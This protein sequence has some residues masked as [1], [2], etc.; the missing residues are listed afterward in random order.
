MVDTPSSSEVQPGSQSSTLIDSASPFYIHPSDSLGMLLAEPL[1]SDP[2]HKLWD[3]CNDMVISWILNYLSKDIAESV[4]YSRTAKEIW[5]DL[6]ARFGQC[7]GAQLY[8]LQKELSNAVQGNTNIAGYF[9]RIKK[10]WDEL[11]A[12]ITLNHCSCVCICGGKIKTI[13]S[14]Q[15]GRLIQFLMGLNSSYSS[16]KSSILM[17]DPLPSVSQAYSLLIQDE[18]Q[19]EVHMESSPSHGAFSVSHQQFGHNQRFNNTQNFLGN[20]DGRFKTQFDK[21][22]TGLFCTHCKLT[23]H[24]V[25]KCYR[26]IGFPPN[27]KFTKSKKEKFAAHSTSNV[28]GDQSPDV[29]ASANCAGIFTPHFNPSFYYFSSHLTSNS[30]ILDLGASDHMNFDYSLLSNVTHLPTLLYVNLPNSHKLKVTHKGSV[31]I[32]PNLVIDNVLFVPDFKFNLLSVQKL[33]SQFHCLLTFFSSGAVF[34]V[35]SMKSPLV[36]SEVH[37]GL[38]IFKSAP[39]QSSLVPDSSCPVSAS[40]FLSKSVSSLQPCWQDAMAKEFEALQLNHTWDLV[41]LPLGKRALPSKWVYKVKYKA[42]GSIERYKARLVIQGDVQRAAVAI[43]KGWDLFQLDVN[44]AFLHGNLQEEVYMRIP[45]GLQVSGSN[46]IKDLGLAHYFLGLELIREEQGLIVTQRKFTTDLLSEF[47]CLDKKPVV[48]PLEPSTKLRVDVGDILPDPLVYR[49]LVGKLNFLTH[50]RPDLSFAVQHLSQYMQSPRMP[51]YQAG[52]HCLRYLLGNPGLGLLIKSSSVFDL[53]AYCDSDW[54]SCPETRR[55]ISGYFISFGGTPISWKSKKQ[56]LISLSSAEAEY[57]S[58]CRVVAEITWLV[59]LLSDL[60]VSPSLPIPLHSD[61]QAAIHIAK[62][63][64]F[65]ERTKH[66]ELDCHFVRQQ[67]LAGLISLHYLPSTSQLADIFTKPLHGFPH[68][69]LLGK[70]G[71]FPHPSNLRG[72]V[73]HDSPSSPEKKKSKDASSNS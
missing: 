42:D 2:T 65:H 17:M 36:L 43:K 57:R 59:R 63:L 64:V 31:H 12:F 13:K 29:N 3:R 33:T 41:P 22:K 72:V 66:V 62:N 45:A 46:L 4:L 21:P 53:Q 50:T 37:D 8:Q 1:P 68:H 30:W 70:L 39:I 34:Q 61:S 35:P 9:T 47:D 20:Q 19:R 40:S 49:R 16:V 32:L 38:Y 51:H 14:H 24:E 23:N 55:S 18:K 60:T 54:G 56:P 52:L 73:E 25:S 15:D 71:I 7:N 27:F 58:M 44:N 26:L 28:Q 11:D 5:K 48:S 69:H 10:L 67:F 6:S